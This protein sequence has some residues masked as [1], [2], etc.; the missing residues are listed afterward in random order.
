MRS[1]SSVDCYLKTDVATEHQANKKLEQTMKP[2]AEQTYS[3]VWLSSVWSMVLGRKIPSPTAQ[4]VEATGVQGLMLLVKL[5]PLLFHLPRCIP[6][7]INSIRK[8]P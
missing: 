1:V 6:S 2:K 3:L 7:S 4:G 5:Q 8:S